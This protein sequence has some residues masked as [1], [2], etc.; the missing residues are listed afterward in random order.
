MK[1]DL[2]YSKCVRCKSVAMILTDFGLMGKLAFCTI[3]WV[4]LAG[5]MARDFHQFNK[6][7]ENYLAELK[8]AYSNEE[9]FKEENKKPK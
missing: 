7:D 6:F 3:C 5:C 9:W 1:K 2:N 4:G 8:K